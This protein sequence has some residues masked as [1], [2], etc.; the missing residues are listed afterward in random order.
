MTTYTAAIDAREISFDAPTLIAAK[1]RARREF[2]GGYIGDRIRI[3]EH[4]NTHGPVVVST[5]T[6]GRKGWRDAR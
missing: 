6:V 1:V 2:D 5:G 4:T 3:A